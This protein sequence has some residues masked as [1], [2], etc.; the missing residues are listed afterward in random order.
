MVESRLLQVLV[1]PLRVLVSA[2]AWS[3]RGGQG[4]VSRGDQEG[5]AVFVAVSPPYSA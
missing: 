2:A 4:P 5:E 3:V 1:K